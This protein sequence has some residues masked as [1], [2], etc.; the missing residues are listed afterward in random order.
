MRWTM[1]PEVYATASACRYGKM[2]Q[3]IK[4]TGRT[5]EPTEK[6]RSGMLMAT[7]MKVNSKMTNQMAMVCTLAPMAQCMRASG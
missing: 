4:E 6:G 5:I 1:A 2:E 3:S 7:T